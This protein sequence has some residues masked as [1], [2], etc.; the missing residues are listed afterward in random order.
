V[1]A[2]TCVDIP[3]GDPVLYVPCDSTMRGTFARMEHEAECG[4]DLLSRAESILLAAGK[5]ADGDVAGDDVVAILH[6]HLFLKI[7][8]EYER[9]MSS[10]WRPYLNSLP[11]YHSNGA[12]MTDFCFGCLPP[13][14][15]GL[16]LDDR[17][18][19]LR[20]ANAMAALLPSGIISSTS[21]TD[22]ALTSWAYAIVRTRCLD[23][24]DGGGGGGTDACL[25]PMADYFNHGGDADGGAV[26]V[27]VSF[28]E[29]GNCR[30]YANRYVESG[31]SLRICYGDPSNPSMLL[32]RYGFL[33][34]TSSS[35]FCKLVISDPCSE[36]VDLGCHPTRMLFYDDGGISQ[37]VWDVL[38]YIELGKVS[39]GNRG[40]E[41]GLQDSFHAAY[42]MGDESTMRWHRESCFPQTLSALREHVNALL[43]ELEELGLGLEI[44]R[45][46]GRDANLHPRLR[47]IMRHNEFVRNTLEVVRRNL[48]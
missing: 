45:K 12:S 7:V 10:P 16:S 28:D 4:S 30:A 19:Y 26:N 5:T 21:H 31:E 13:Y 33:D 36:L 20:F 29:Y 15:A 23:V 41:G 40:R 48:E 11:R 47:L 27:D 3:A 18:R 43:N 8:R 9:G 2:A 22:G 42:A 6:F 32:A 44:Q 37:E 25:V 38:T 24:H 17:R 1:C 35:T 14:A 39:G 34:D 46:Q